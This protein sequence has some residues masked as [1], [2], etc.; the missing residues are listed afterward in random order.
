M[1]SF[2][3][4]QMKRVGTKTV[5]CRYRTLSTGLT[6]I[7]EVDP[8]DTDPAVFGHARWKVVAL[9]DSA[10]SSS[11][12]LEPRP[13]RD[14][15]PKPI[16][17]VR[18][19]EFA[20][21][22]LKSHNLRGFTELTGPIYGKRSLGRRGRID[23][24]ELHVRRMLLATRDA[25]AHSC[26]VDEDKVDQLTEIM[27]ERGLEFLGNWH[28][29]RRYDGEFAR[30]S[31]ADLEHWR[32]WQACSRPFGGGGEPWLGLIISPGVDDSWFSPRPTAHIIRAD[33]AGEPTLDYV[34]CEYP[35]GLGP[36]QTSVPRPWEL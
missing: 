25:Y 30:Y 8:P 12:D 6:L 3:N 2:W 15:G 10:R 19:D 5:A 16:M 1:S 14:R 18:F 35:G 33:P 4:A 32:A 23:G 27:A 29:H 9:P 17:L 31:P 13:R 36:L 21:D 22:E 7:A 24:T 20:W 28:T 34:N 11:L 26:A